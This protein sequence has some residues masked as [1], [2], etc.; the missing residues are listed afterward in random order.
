MLLGCNYS[1]Q[2]IELIQEEKI[3]VDYIKL[4]LYEIYEGTFDISRSISPVLVHG[5]GLDERA[6]MSSSVLDNINWQDVNSNIKKFNSPHIGIHLFAQKDDWEGIPTKEGIIERMISVLKKW[7]ENIEV[8]LLVENMIWIPYYM[9]KDLFPYAVDSDLINKVCNEANVDLLLD[10]AHAKVTAYHANES[11]FSY[12]ER[13]PLEKVKEIHTVG[14]MM[15]EEHGLEDKHQ[16]MQEEDFEI[17]NWLLHRTNPKVVTLEYGGPGE[18]FSW[19]SDKKA[20]ER[21]LSRLMEICKR[22]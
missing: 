20:L 5:F 6:S 3:N 16:E 15:T 17:L 12:L 21:Q 10:I 19:R 22:Y 9:E 8:P 14:T 11:I 4:G 18:L 1:S 7:Q 13:L 2:L